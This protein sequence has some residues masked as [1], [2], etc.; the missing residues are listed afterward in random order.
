[1]SVRIQLRGDTAANW[2]AI[3]PILAQREAGFVTDT[4]QLKFG[5]GTT[6]WN[7]LG[8]FSPSEGA[9]VLSFNT[10]TGSVTLSKT[11]VTGTGVTYSDVGADQAGAAS[12]AQSA[13]ISAAEAASN[14]RASNLSDVASAATARTNLGLGTAATHATGDFDAGGLAAAAAS[15]SIPLT[16]KGA[17]SGVAALSATGSALSVIA[18]GSTG[19][20]VGSLLVD[21][22]GTAT[23]F[24]AYC[25]QSNTTGSNNT[26]S[27]FQCLQSNTTGSNNTGSGVNCLLANTTG[28]QN[29]GSGV[30]CL[31]S[32]TTGNYNT[33][34]GAYCLLA[35]TTGSNNTGSGAY[36]LQAN[37]VGGNNTG[38]GAYCLY[39]NTTGSNNTGSGVYC[40][41]ANTTGNYNTGSG[42]A[43]GYTATPANATTTAN[44]QTLIGYNT[45]QSSATQVDY[46]TCLGYQALC[47]A[48]GAVAIGTDNTGAGAVSTVANQIQLGTALH[49]VNFPGKLST[50]VGG[51]AA[52]VGSGTLIGGT[53]TVATTAITANSLIFVTDSTTGA[54][55]NVGS[56]VV[57]AKSAGTS[58][59]VTS[60]NI[61]DTSTFSW[62]I[63]N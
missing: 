37:T 11:D 41:L 1:M 58:F 23:A 38:S 2:T 57:S 61:L 30:N 40:L 62:L 18:S 8:Y 48:S 56:L 60:T 54:L 5:D 55:T 14:Q 4:G 22:S 47:G 10:R 6:A 27:G 7:S 28:I 16:Q 46:I 49:T 33:G 34:S 26:G 25:L 21:T 17:L 3:N 13:A 39:A 53:A 12:S 29:T 59:T 43:A 51:A 44:G 45:G 35:N 31:Q 63:I 9:E 52:I 32:N 15:A 24:G 36:C 42:Y 20:G 19:F 50:P